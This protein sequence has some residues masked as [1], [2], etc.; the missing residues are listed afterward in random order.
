[1]KSLND[2]L[3]KFVKSVKCD[4]NSLPWSFNLF[5]RLRAYDEKNTSEIY[6]TN[7]YL[8][9]EMRLKFYQTT[10]QTRLKTEC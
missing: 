10:L 8:L 7:L 2:H 3:H 5:P 9:L 1:M 4:N 6:K